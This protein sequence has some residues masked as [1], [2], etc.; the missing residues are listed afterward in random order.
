MG[1]IGRSDRGQSV[2]RNILLVIGDNINETPNIIPLKL[3]HSKML[4]GGFH[5]VRLDIRRAGGLER[6]FD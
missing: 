5:H 6:Y 2:S 1:S 3:R 4:G